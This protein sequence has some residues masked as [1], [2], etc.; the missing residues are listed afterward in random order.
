MSETESSAAE[1][2]PTITS[3]DDPDAPWNQK[4]SDA[5]IAH[6]NDGVIEEFRA[7]G[8][9]V[10][11]AYEGG[12]IVLLTTTGAKSG[13]PHVVP[14]G[15]LRREETMYVSSFI[16]DKYPAWFYNV[17]ANRDVTI[18]WG[19]TTYRG[20]A[21]ALSGAEYD[22]FAGWVVANNPLLAEYQA[23]VTRPLPLV[24]LELGEP[25]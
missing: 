15:L 19:P 22:E 25:I 11:G 16:E 18:E 2:K 13:K 24:V 7:N 20:T 17:K 23:K 3:Y 1:S 12:E 21:R 4:Y 9:K 8:G 14:L 5:E 6:W 10:G